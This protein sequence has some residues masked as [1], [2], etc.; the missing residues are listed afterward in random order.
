M[1][2]VDVMEVVVVGIVSFKMG[3]LQQH[4]S[5]KRFCPYCGRTFKRQIGTRSSLPANM[6][7]NLIVH[8]TLT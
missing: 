3:I 4:V 5:C 8:L 6:M 2:C 1:I 7:Q